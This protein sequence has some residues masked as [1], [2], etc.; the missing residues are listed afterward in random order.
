M[1]SISSKER[2]K[3]IKEED[4]IELAKEL[5]CKYY[6]KNGKIYDFSKRNIYKQVLPIW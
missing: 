3:V 4:I 5:N 6:A 1:E 2:E